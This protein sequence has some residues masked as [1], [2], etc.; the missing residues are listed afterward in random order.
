MNLA[1]FIR[2]LRAYHLAD[3]RD[4]HL[5]NT[6]ARMRLTVRGHHAILSG[7]AA[8]DRCPG[9]AEYGRGMNLTRVHGACCARKD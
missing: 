9:M 5:F 7:V 6:Y 4:A 2:T 8:F 3:A 1:R